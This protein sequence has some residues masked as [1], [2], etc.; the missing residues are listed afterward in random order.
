MPSCF[1]YPPRKIGAP[2]LWPNLL[3]QFARRKNY[4]ASSPTTSPFDLARDIPITSHLFELLFPLSVSYFWS[5]SFILSAFQLKITNGIFPNKLVSNVALAGSSTE[6]WQTQKNRMWP[7]ELGY[8]LLYSFSDVRI[9]SQRRRK[10]PYFQRKLIRF[11][12]T[13]GI[14]R[15]AHK[16]EGTTDYQTI[17]L[18]QG[19]P[20]LFC[21]KIDLKRPVHMRNSNVNFL[22]SVAGEGTVGQPA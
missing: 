11:A 12:P 13:I 6:S 22:Y 19:K 17:I 4:G 14:G 15:K 3:I 8:Y 18:K 2:A 9:V 1:L 20:V 21:V 16:T 7:V 10:C 5:F